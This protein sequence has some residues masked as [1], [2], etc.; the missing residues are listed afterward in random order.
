MTPT[1]KI[2]E[3]IKKDIEREQQFSISDDWVCLS[4]RQFEHILRK[5]LS[6][7]VILDRGVLVERNRIWPDCND[8]YGVFKEIKELLSDNNGEDE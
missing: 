8:T 2:I 3:E 1:D 4:E 7:K 6:S 5:H